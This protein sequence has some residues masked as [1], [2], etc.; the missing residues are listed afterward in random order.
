MAS[1]QQERRPAPFHAD[2][3]PAQLHLPSVPAHTIGSPTNHNAHA[4]HLPDLKSLGLPDHH[5]Y[6]TQHHNTRADPSHAAWQHNGSSPS[7]NFPTTSS[8]TARPVVADAGSP[9]DVS[10][11]MSMDDLRHRDLSVSMEDADVRMAAEALSGL[12]NPDFLRS[13]RTAS[14]PHNTF[15]SSAIAVDSLNNTAANSSISAQEKA[16]TTATSTAIHSPLSAPASL[17]SDVEPEPLLRLITDTH[18]WLGNTISGSMIAYDGAKHYSPR[19]VRGTAEFVERNIG[20]PMVSTVGYVSRQ[21]GVDGRLRRYL[22]DRRLSDDGKIN[23]PDSKRRRVNGAAQLGSN[24]Q[25][26]EKGGLVSSGTASPTSEEHR[27]RADSRASHHSAM[28]GVESLPAYDENR[29]PVY[30]EYSPEVSSNTPRPEAGEAP[31]EQVQQ[32][33]LTSQVLETTAGLGV[34]LSD[35]SLRSLK[36]SLRVLS[37]ASEHIG[38]VMQALKRVL[39]EYE[40]DQKCEDLLTANEKHSPNPTSPHSLSAAHRERSERLARRI[41]ELGDNIWNVLRQTIG[42]ISRYTGSALPEN[43]ASLVRR[44]LMSLPM[45]WRNAATS[46]SSSSSAASNSGS[47]SL[48]A[49][50]HQ[51]DTQVL[52]GANRM[53]NFGKESLEMLTQVSLVVS[54]TV[55]S[56]EQWLDSMGRQRRQDSA[57]DVPVD[58]QPQLWI[59]QEQHQSPPQPAPLSVAGQPWTGDQKGP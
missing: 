47:P 27:R 4:L 51:G 46:S 45:R 37:G 50:A 41:K 23:G 25:D 8:V 42:T 33:S 16:Y 30:E 56:A 22:G 21:T 11:Q 36:Y 19:F 9:M 52:M 53:M 7:P 58:Q 38:V 54:G 57:S 17:P 28:S 12:G 13:P 35:S 5:H 44:Q 10:S 40:Q 59:K 39:E 29:S 48:E 6:Q 31:P 20:T 49:Q 24:G 34:A 55:R 1:M 18:P 32:R 14:F 3:D 2:H 15:P 43:A 26:V